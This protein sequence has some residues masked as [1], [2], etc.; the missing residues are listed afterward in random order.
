MQSVLIN[1]GCPASKFACFNLK[2][3]WIHV[4]LSV[5]VNTENQR[6]NM[7]SLRNWIKHMNKDFLTLTEHLKSSL[8]DELWRWLWASKDPLNS[9]VFETAAGF[10]AWA[11]SNEWSC[12]WA[13]K[14]EALLEMLLTDRRIHVKSKVTE[15]TTHYNEAF[16][17]L[18]IIVSG[19]LPVWYKDPLILKSTDLMQTK[20]I[21]CVFLLLIEN[22]MCCVQWVPPLWLL[23]TLSTATNWL[24]LTAVRKITEKNRN[25]TNK[26]NFG[27]LWLFLKK[28]RRKFSPWWGRRAL[29]P[30]DGIS[31]S[32]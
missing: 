6:I 18:G 21:L 23:L 13:L 8:Q 26:V 11:E 25:A 32:F 22:L 31:G 9:A 5:R 3:T 4:K 16:I 1:W 14:E 2:M 12:A 20:R 24:Y 29:A 7:K 10:S 27:E 15:E 17:K 28:K 30:S 19:V